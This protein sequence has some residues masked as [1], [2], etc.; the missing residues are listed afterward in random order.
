ML[1]DQGLAFTYSGVGITIRVAV[2]GTLDELIRTSNYLT[3]RI[4]ANDCSL[5]CNVNFGAES[6]GGLNQVNDSASICAEIVWIGWV[7]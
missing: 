3:L 7:I 1:I 2:F 6:I 4:F 5:R